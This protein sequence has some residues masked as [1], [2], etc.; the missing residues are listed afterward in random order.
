MSTATEE[1]CEV[2]VTLLSKLTGVADRAAAHASGLSCVI[3]C[4]RAER[5]HLYLPSN[6][7][8][9]P[10]RAGPGLPDQ[11]PAITQLVDGVL[12]CAPLS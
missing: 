10:I 9:E 12:F 11:S 4:S 8:A 2:I 6:E 5:F 3:R 1:V 7:G